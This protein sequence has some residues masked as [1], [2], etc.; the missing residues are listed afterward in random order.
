MTRNLMRA[1]VVVILG[2]CFVAGGVATASAALDDTPTVTSSTNPSE[3]VGANWWR[4]GWGNSVYPQFSIAGP[5][6]GATEVLGGFLYTVDRD[7]ATVI[8]TSTP[9]GYYRSVKPSGTHLTQ[10]LDMPGIY[11]YDPTPPLEPGAVGIEGTWSTTSG[12][13]AAWG[14]HRMTT[15]CR[16]G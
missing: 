9:Y 11:A 8:D 10:I 14:T 12:P 1:L 3:A 5:S 16:S 15:S 13:S 4:M 7:P 2:V 6:V